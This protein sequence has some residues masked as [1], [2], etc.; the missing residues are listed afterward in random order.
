MASARPSGVRSP[1]SSTSL[2]SLPTHSASAASC[3][4]DRRGAG[5]GGELGQRQQ[6]DRRQGV[7]QP[8]RLLDV[9]V[10]VL[11]VI[12]VDV[13][14]VVVG[15][16]TSLSARA[17]A[18]RPQTPCNHGQNA[19][20][21]SAATPARSTTR[22][23]ARPPPGMGGRSRRPSRWTGGRRH[24]GARVPLRCYFAASRVRRTYCM[25]PPWR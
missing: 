9:D 21:A 18:A 10:L 3:A 20:R 8:E 13:M 22:L 23:S 25:M 15:H 17:P 2:P 16:A 7:G 11:E 6:A 14:V 24:A 5:A 12:V 4:G 1:S 19:H